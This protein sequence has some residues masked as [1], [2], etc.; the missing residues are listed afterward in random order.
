VDRRKPVKFDMGAFVDELE[1][2]VNRSVEYY[3][4]VEENDRLEEKIKILEE[5]Q[6]T[7][8][9]T[10]ATEYQRECED[11]VMVR[12]AMKLAPI[13]GLTMSENYE[14]MVRDFLAKQ[15]GTSNECNTN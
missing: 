4:L 13:F 6:Q 10:K 15:K 11:E 14:R 8:I 9:K 3:K 12:L 2:L 5:D 1:M 7:L